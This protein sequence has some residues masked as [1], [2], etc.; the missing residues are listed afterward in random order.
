MYRSIVVPLDGT[1]FGEH[2]LPVALDLARRAGARLQLM[3]AHATR[4]PDVH[5][6]AHEQAYLND[7]I[8]HLRS[9]WDGEIDGNLIH[10]PV[11]VALCEYAA[12]V[13]ADLIVM[14]THARSG[15]LRLWMGCV[16][17]AVVRRAPIPVLLLRPGAQPPNLRAMPPALGHMLVALD[18][19]ALAESILPHALGLGQLAE[20]EYTLMQAIE[21]PPIESIGQEEQGFEGLEARARLYLSGVAERLR[22]EGLRARAA[23]VAAEDGLAAAILEYAGAK[24][25]DLIAMATHGRHGLD[26]ALAGSVADEVLHGAHLPVLLHCPAA[27]PRS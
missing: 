16:A 8:R 12:A 4:R 24:R 18:G 25:V 3:H 10:E 5:S 14:S 15:L 17:D 20:A 19:S 7:L 22:A 21:P 26:R 13:R 11:T 2:A 1:E 9:I 6:Q 23:T 27:G